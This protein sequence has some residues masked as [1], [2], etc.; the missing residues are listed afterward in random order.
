V[1]YPGAALPASPAR[2]IGREHELAQLHALLAADNVRMVTL[3]GVGGIGKTRLAL[4]AA[5]QQSP[6]FGDGARFVDLSPVHEPAIVLAAIAAAIDLGS[7]A[8]QPLL[9]ALKR[10]LFGLHVLLVLDNFEQVLSAAPLVAELLADCPR[11]TVIVTS[12]APLRISWEHE[13]AIGPLEVPGS[14]LDERFTQLVEVPSVALLLER[15][16]QLGHAAGDLADVAAICRRLDGMPL[17]LELAA[18]RARILSPRALLERLDHPIRLLSGGPRDA[19]ARHQSLSAAFD[20]TYELLGDADKQLFRQLGV[21]VG[22]CTLEAAARV[23]GDPGETGGDMLAGLER[24]VESGLVR[25]ADEATAQARR[26]VLLEPVREY[27]VE[28]LDAS[29][30]AERVRQRH[31]LVYLAFAEQADP[32]LRGP[33]QAEWLARLDREHANLDAALRWLLERAQ[34]EPALRLVAALAWFWWARGMS[35]LG[36]QWTAK[37]FAVPCLEPAPHGVVM[38]RA[39][40]QSGAGLLAYSQGDLPTADAHLRTALELYAGVGHTSGIGFVLS[41]L[42]NCA[43]AA[44]DLSRAEVLY[45]RS[46]EASRATGDTRGIA[47]AAL[48]LGLIAFNR[49]QFDRSHTLL[50]ESVALERQAGDARSL[51]IALAVLALLQCYR[52]HVET[53][54]EHLRECLALWHGDRDRAMLPLLLELC[55]VIAILTANPLR[56]LKLGSAATALREEIGAVRP[57]VW[58]P[59][60][61]RWMQQA[62]SAAGSEPSANAWQEGRVLTIQASLAEAQALASPGDSAG[63]SPATD[64]LTPRE[65]EILRLVAGGATNKE[66]ASHLHLSVATVERHVFNIYSK[67]G[68]R[69]RAEATAFAITRGIATR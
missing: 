43:Q 56:G 23:L 40:A 27:A 47:Q 64:R 50:T 21:F 8:T 46:S 1:Q 51:S 66:I 37:A 63:R 11:L 39:R 3:T 28:L 29:D 31:A 42:A 44:G 19:P 2:L 55:A 58:T 7:S 14:E 69:G 13:I 38:A 9:A 30:E 15:M 33:H 35:R 68:A 48:N 57:P 62:R 53:A 12:R 49:R 6:L 45:E 61:E 24:L 18:A 41:M 22:G 65:T 25:G 60:F 4:E 5:R 52:K 17:A 34:G 26:V 36:L 10:A 20:S 54:R 16:G 32:E 59:E 67:I